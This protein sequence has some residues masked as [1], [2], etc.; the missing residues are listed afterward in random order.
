MAAVRESIVADTMSV[1]SRQLNLISA[2]IEV[3]RLSADADDAVRWIMSGDSCAMLV[4]WRRST[5][6][7]DGPSDDTFFAA[8]WY[9]NGGFGR[10]SDIAPAPDWA[11]MAYGHLPAKSRTGQADSAAVPVIEGLRDPCSGQGCELETVSGG[12]S[13]RRVGWTADS[14]AVFA[15]PESPPHWVAAD[16]QTRTV[17]SRRAETPIA[18]QWTSHGVTDLRHSPGA[19]RAAGGAY[20]F[21]ERNDSIVMHGPDR[22][23]VIVARYVGHGVPAIATRNGEY[24]LAVRR[25]E[26]GLEVVVYYFVLFHAMLQSSCDR[27]PT[28]R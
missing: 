5:A 2:P 10:V 4:E 18:V 20:S 24:L 26:D 6:P 8:E 23:G 22:H 19:V 12:V 14:V 25:T 7:L 28:T 13:G 16:P 27:T 1:A 9:G 21:S 17:S 11:W 3:L 15:G